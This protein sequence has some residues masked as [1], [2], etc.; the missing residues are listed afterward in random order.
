MV[1]VRPDDMV[2]EIILEPEFTVETHNALLAKDP[3]TWKN[4]ID[5]IEICVERCRAGEGTYEEHD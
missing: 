3:E 5:A 4:L 1:V 2:Y